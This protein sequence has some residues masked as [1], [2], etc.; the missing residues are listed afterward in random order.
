MPF[1]SAPALLDARHLRSQFRWHALLDCTI[2]LRRTLAKGQVFQIRDAQ[3]VLNFGVRIVH[4]LLDEAEVSPGIPVAAGVHRPL[5]GPAEGRRFEVDE[6]IPLFSDLIGEIG[7]LGHK[8]G[9]EFAVADCTHAMTPC[10]LTTK[11]I[12]RQ[13]ITVDSDFRPICRSD[14][15]PNSA[16]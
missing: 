13:P 1:V 11:A 14:S 12:R 3:G 16:M 6:A 15:P 2:P 9:D 10:R 5:G 8:E 7:E 4:D